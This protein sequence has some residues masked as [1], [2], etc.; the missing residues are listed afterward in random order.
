MCKKMMLLKI[1]KKNLQSGV[2]LVGVLVSIVVISVMALAFAKFSR[3]STKSIAE[4][5]GQL[6]LEAYKASLSER[7]D[8][9]RTLAISDTSTFP[10][11]CPA[12]PA[13]T[14]QFKI[15]L[16]GDATPEEQIKIGNAQFTL[17]CDSKGLFAEKKTS[18]M[19]VAPAFSSELRLCS[20]FFL[21]ANPLCPK[22]SS[23]VGFVNGAPICGLKPPAATGGTGGTGGTGETGGGAGGTT[24]EITST[25]SG[26]GNFTTKTVSDFGTIQVIEGERCRTI[27]ETPAGVLKLKTGDWPVCSDAQASPP[28]CP[29]GFTFVTAYPDRFGP[30]GSDINFKS[31]CVK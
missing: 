10:V 7:I 22:E 26:T 15:A 28:A 17:R 13:G 6:S 27:K 9:M 24:G 31:I 18:G 25:V 1:R 8:C 21:S 19:P 5:K 4:V 29:E 23:V 11:A 14:A 12:K 20:Q 3:T 2:S 16:R 30:Y